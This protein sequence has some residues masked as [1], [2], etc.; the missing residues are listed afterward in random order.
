MK[1]KFFTRKKIILYFFLI[2]TMAFF[3]FPFYWIVLTSIQPKDQLYAPTPNFIPENI[4][5]DNTSFA[6]STFQALYLITEVGIVIL[7]SAVLF[8][9]QP[10]VTLFFCFTYLKT[11]QI[12]N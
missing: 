7:M 6:F 2:I 1:S 3:L 4:T 12:I 10:A 9:L 5:I 11:F 8:Y